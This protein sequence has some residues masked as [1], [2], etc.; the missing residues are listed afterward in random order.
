VRESHLDGN[1]IE[2][3]SVR[4]ERFM[5]SAELETDL[6]V[7]SNLRP[8]TFEEYPGQTV[9]KENLK[10]YVESAKKRNKTLD[11]I[12]LHGPPGL[13][14]TTL[15]HIVAHEMGVSFHATSA[16]AIERAG[17]LAGILAGLEPGSIL[18]IDE[19]HRLPIQ[20]EELMYSAME[21]FAMDILVGQGP[22]A[23]AMRV[24]VSPFTLIGAT[25]RV[26]LLSRPFQSRFGIQERL[27]FY[28]VF[29]LMKIVS[30]TSDILSIK[31][32]SEAL[33]LIALSSRG[34]PRIANRILKRVWDFALVADLDVIGEDIARRALSRLEIDSNGLDRTDR[35]ILRTILER[36][37]GGPVGVEAIAVSIGEDRSTVEEVYEPFLVF[38][39]Y[40]S[41]GPRGRSITE[42][43]KSVL[44]EPLP[45]L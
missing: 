43:G 15:A 17:D 40:L 1:S 41:R 9:A 36:Y 19:I 38:Q 16:P 34:T 28:D 25:T 26:S 12:L 6:R 35:V 24:P 5:D 7:T 10:V 44:V 22:S 13:G 18:F 3:S 32:D 11:H 31:I 37:E 30:R 14:K 27:E 20:L 8:H 45:F 42:A 21:D 39:G 23:R 29:S 4:L 2:L 33:E